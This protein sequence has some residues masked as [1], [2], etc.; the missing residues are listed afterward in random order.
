MEGISYYSTQ[1][2]QYQGPEKKPQDPEDITIL[3]DHKESFHKGTEHLLTLS[4]NEGSFRLEWLKEHL[5]IGSSEHTVAV[6]IHDDYPPMTLI[7]FC[8]H[9]NQLLTEK[10]FLHT[11]IKVNWLVRAEHPSRESLEAIWAFGKS[12]YKENQRIVNNVLVVGEGKDIED[13]IYHYEFPLK[14]AKMHFDTVWTST[15]VSPVLIEEASQSPIIKESGVYLITGGLGGLGLI[16]SKYLAAEKQH[17]VRLILIGRSQL[18]PDK[19]N[20]MESITGAEVTYWPTDITH[21]DQ[22]DKLIKDIDETYGRLDG[23]IHSAGVIKDDF[24]VRKS[25][26]T[27]SKV[28]TPKVVGIRSLLRL[29]VHFVP[30]F[31]VAFSSI[32]GIMGNAGQTDYAYGNAYM[33]AV[34]R[35]QS[36][37]GKTKF[38]SINWPFWTDGDMTIAQDELDIIE[39]TSGIK[40]L[41]TADGLRAFRKMFHQGLTQ[42]MPLFGHTEIIT[43]Y[44]EKDLRLQVSDTRPGT[45]ESADATPWKEGL[46]TLL[47]EELTS[48]LRLDKE[49][50]DTSEKLDAFGVD[51]IMISKFNHTLES[52]FEGIPKTILF[53]VSTIDEFV[54]LLLHRYSNQVIAYFKQQDLASKGTMEMSQKIVPLDLKIFEEDLWAGFGTEQDNPPDTA[55]AIVGMAGK[56][57]QGEE[58]DEFWKLI[59]QGTSV[60]QT[61]P[62]DRWEADRY[63]HPDPAMIKEG[64]M[65][66][67]WGAFLEDVRGFDPLFFNIS[68][69]ELSLIDPQERLFLETSWKLLKESGYSAHRLASMGEQI[70]NVGV[71]AGATS[72]TYNL[73]GVEEQSK[74]NPVLPRSLAWSIANRVSYTFDLFGPSIS[75]DTACSSSL[76]VVHMACQSLRNKECQMAIAGGVNLYL[77]PQKYLGM[78]AMGMLSPTGKCHTFGEKADGFLPGE[79]VGAILIK[80]LE[81]AIK[82]KDHIYGII[83]GTAVNHG[84]KTNGYTVPNPKA[85]TQLIRTAL[86][87]AGLD[88]ED[89]SYIEAHGTGTALGD[90][91]EVRGIVNAFERPSLKD[92]LYLGSIKSNIGHLESAAGVAGITK[93]LLSMMHRT[94][95]PLPI[96]DGVNAEI[97]FDKH[98][99]EIPQN[100][101]PWPAEKRK[102][103]GV[104]SF[105]AGGSNGHVIIGEYLPE[106]SIDPLPEPEAVL[107]TVSVTY[108]ERVSE[109]ARLLARN[110]D[111]HLNQFATEK[112]FLYALSYNLLCCTDH[113]AHR[114]AA[115]VD[116]YDGLKSFLK[117]LEH[118]DFEGIHTAHKVKNK[119]AEQVLLAMLRYTKEEWE[120]VRQYWSKGIKHD[121]TELFSVH[122]PY[123]PIPATL[124]LKEPYWVEQISDLGPRQ[125]GMPVEGAYTLVKKEGNKSIYLVNDPSELF[126][127]GPWY[128]LDLM[129]ECLRSNYFVS[130]FEIV[131]LQWGTVASQHDV[132]DLLLELEHFENQLY[133]RMYEMGLEDQLYF[134]AVLRET[135]T[136]SVAV[137]TGPKRA[138]VS[139]HQSFAQQLAE[140]GM[141]QKALGGYLN[142][143]LEP[144]FYTTFKEGHPTIYNEQAEP[145]LQLDE[146]HSYH[147]ESRPATVHAYQWFWKDTPLLRSEKVLHEDSGVDLFVKIT[148]TSPGWETMGAVFHHSEPYELIL[149]GQS[150]SEG[151]K[152][153]VLGDWDHQDR[154]FDWWKKLGL[155]K[156]GHRVI[157]SW[158]QDENEE[159]LLRLL[160]LFAKFGHEYKNQST[161]SFLLLESRAS[162]GNTN[163]KVLGLLQSMSN[164]WNSLPV[165]W[166][167]YTSLDRT[168]L[169]TV[170]EDEL[171]WGKEKVVM[172]GTA[173]QRQTLQLEKYIPSPDGMT[174]TTKPEKVLVIGGGGALAQLVIGHLISTHGSEVIAL[175][176]RPQGEYGSLHAQ[177]IYYQCDITKVDEVDTTLGTILREHGEVDTVFFFAG[178]M[179]KHLLHEKDWDEM[180]RII[181]PKE[182]GM[183]TLLERIPAL[184]PHRLINFSSS[185]VMLG[186]FGQ[187]DY[188]YANGS[189]DDLLTT[190]RQ[191]EQTVSLKWPLWK[192]GGMHIDAEKEAFYLEATGMEYLSNSEGLE[193]LDQVLQDPRLQ[194]LLIIKGTDRF[195]HNFLKVAE[196]IPVSETRRKVGQLSA[197]SPVEFGEKIKALFSEASGIKADKL[198]KEENFGRY[199][200]DSIIIKNIS[201]SLEKLLQLPVAPSLL[202]TYDTLGAL[203]DYLYEQSEGH[204]VMDPTLVS[205]GISN[206]EMGI[207]EIESEVMAVFRESCGI[208]EQK[209]GPRSGFGLFELDRI[210]IHRFSTLLSRKFFRNIPIEKLTSFADCRAVATYLLEEK[211]DRPAVPEV[212]IATGKTEKKTATRPKAFENGPRLKRTVKIAPTQQEHEIAIIGM[213]GLFPQS[214]DLI[215]FWE[216]LKA[217]HSLEREVWGHRWGR[218][219]KKFDDIPDKLAFIDDVEAFD[220]PFFKLSPREAKVM[221]PQHRLFMQIVW[222][223][224]ENGGYDPL[225]MENKH[226]GVFC[227][228]Q[229]NDYQMMLGTQEEF[230]AQM[231]TGT[232]HAMLTNRISYMLNLSGP[233]EAIDTAC[234]SSMIAINRAVRAI[235][236]GECDWAVAGGVSLIL[237]QENIYGANKMGILSPNGQCKTFD[238]L[239]DGYVKGEGVGAIVLKPLKKAIEDNDPIYGVIKGVATNHGGKA[240]S[241]TSPNPKAQSSLIVKAMEEAKLQP[242]DIN[243]IETHGTGTVLGDPIEIDGINRAF[244]SFGTPLEPKSCAVGALKANI[245]HLEPASGIAG[246][247]KA[248]LSMRYKKLV[249][250]ANL[251]QVNP[252]INFK[253]SSLYLNTELRD[254][255]EPSSGKGTRTVGVSSFGFGGANGHVIIS[256]YK[257]RRPVLSETKAV[258]FPF[259]AK[260][261]TALD[262]YLRAFAKD[263]R[264]HQ[265]WNMNHPFTA[266]ARTLQHR[267]QY[268]Y[269]L[270]IIAEDYEQLLDRIFLFLE[271]GHEGKATF[272]NHGKCS[273]ASFSSKG[274]ALE[275]EAQQYIY[276]EKHTWPVPEKPMPKVPLPGYSFDKKNYWFEELS[277]LE[278]KLDITDLLNSINS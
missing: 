154:L 36:P 264:Y 81:N 31:V 210:S 116:S 117:Q 4:E 170:M 200:I 245:G 166:L 113:Y 18:S 144:A 255:P 63:Y 277:K 70:P 66:S 246:V 142:T 60:S 191:A 72:F 217:G 240:N 258:V 62:K 131:S 137:P 187:L 115:I 274:D 208:T 120:P 54:E 195:L 121:W 55:M 25:W 173:G 33:D 79:G 222:Q 211:N 125:L 22:V 107:I 251:T 161:S 176:R 244:A 93:V 134:E 89:L 218:S 196:T 8:F 138:I 43:D 15:S 126:D 250:L 101:Q 262:G 52:Y 30:D 188:A 99:I 111:K 71:F 100:P 229:F 221:D 149:E 234:S 151:E 261:K 238:H 266:V 24:L 47:V 127:Q 162:A 179:S 91:I 186:D 48:L 56:Y 85:Q 243:Y 42:V 73:I 235:R 231:A 130:T 227:G 148:E 133:Y 159:A 278:S 152:R 136:K 156:V 253:G 157:L 46:E 146:L 84:G 102:I 49:D 40:P 171:A 97:S 201:A 23:I 108:P 155:S 263:I 232:S 98:S 219:T 119:K 103:A 21:E 104:S 122:P 35:R 213:S 215:D 158:Q 241:L 233:S 77:H 150:Y 194:D 28:V 83:E 163:Q 204:L 230:V 185:S 123:F 193:L 94:I 39:Q 135:N 2:I 273:E 265:Q 199:G 276:T 105:G 269:K 11:G 51:S 169:S 145:L 206:G 260:S 26:D 132:R 267:G 50:F 44:I 110:C 53:E 1:E 248:L 95:P 254:W 92:T 189:S 224:I 178:K 147:N 82:D 75:V 216:N 165:R 14:P 197:V 86:K 247:I 29:Q 209:V 9:L 140:E 41:S 27:F 239:A 268:R 76:T 10:I 61:I 129:K 252:Y 78:C 275:D 124:L 64:K 184:S 128:C 183:R 90:P 141:P 212:P 257:D 69:K 190:Y 214:A 182:R 181:Q 58:M 175:N 17:G 45:E 139:L 88:M 143:A 153:L 114:Y 172:L 223:S 228:V 226:M 6:Y 168:S 96:E 167:R 106:S 59:K 207:E 109:Y 236:S 160:H 249:P 118:R 20:L 177:A 74:G 87:D 68:P 192:E 271:Q 7:S 32:S 5:P 164:Y 19:S 112:Q 174:K 3:T 237:S 37:E 203:V 256:G 13:L 220:A 38:L 225:T 16:F 205:E 198:D 259:S 34:F 202:F 67:K 270:A 180:N 242:S 57:P 272:Y 80:P 65:Y 12:L